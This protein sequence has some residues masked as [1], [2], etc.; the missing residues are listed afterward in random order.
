MRV[1]ETRQK[2]ESE[3]AP[4]NGIPGHQFDNTEVLG[5]LQITVPSTG[6]FYKKPQ[7]IQKYEEK[8]NSSLFMKSILCKTEK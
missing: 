7:S 4:G 8:E 2:L 5:S 3:K 6:G 1:E